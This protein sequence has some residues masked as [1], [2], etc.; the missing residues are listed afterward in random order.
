MTEVSNIKRILTS[1]R[2][3]HVG[4]DVWEQFVIPRFINEI[5]FYSKQSM[6][7]EGSR[8]SGKTMLLRYLSFQTQFSKLREYIP[9]ESMNRIGLYWKAD[10][11]FLRTMEKRGVDEDEWIGIFEN[12]LTLKLSLEAVNSIEK[13]A[14]SNCQALTF[15]DIEN[16]RILGIEDYGFTTNKLIDLHDEIS[17]KIRKFEMFIQNRK[18]IESEQKIPPTFFSYLIEGIKDST[19][20]LSNIGYSVFIDEYENLLPYQ[21]RLIN[22][23]IKSSSH[24]MT[25][26][27]AIKKNGMPIQD[28]LGPEKIQN[29]HDFSVIDLDEKIKKNDYQI[30]LAEV[31]LK[32]LCDVSDEFSKS[33]GFD[34]NILNNIDKLDLRRSEDYV[35]NCKKLVS[36][37][38]VGR[39][40]NELADEVFFSEKYHSK[41]R[42]EIE[43]AL[44]IRK[45]EES[46]TADNFININ[47]KKASIV[48]SSLLYRKTLS[49]DEVFSEFKNHTEGNESKFDNQTDWNKNNF[50]GC[51]LRI[52]SAYKQNN[53]FYS[54][55]DVYCHL[56]NGNVRHFLEL[57]RSAFSLVDVEKLRINL[58]IDHQSQHLAAR[59]AS[60]DLFKEIKSFSPM[61]HQL[62]ELAEGLGM[63]FNTI[64]NKPEQSEPEIKHFGFK[65]TATRLTEEDVRVL[66][67]AEKWGVLQLD[68]V[69]KEKTTLSVGMYEYILNPI[70]SPKFYISYRKGRKYELTASEFQKLYTAGSAAVSDIIKSSDKPDIKSIQQGLF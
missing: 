17:S 26:N 60:E 66:L 6:R 10:T 45:R 44:K 31:L 35:K 36:N 49:I 41:L 57:C 53:S 20:K 61:G 8:G 55:F 70:Y 27:I 1:I 38:L 42:S 28:T 33:I 54:G 62:T 16:L 51:Y 13:I 9:N 4:M 7:I 48:V 39:S 52:V 46:Y 68:G 11:Q 63:L 47:Y 58:V 3:E 5:D 12:Y 59:T 37:I 56:S 30:F 40:E 21:Q 64:Q 65:N 22:T 2:S 43:K 29:I 69:T 32:R 15:D 14:R 25:F 67:E 50:I 23:K 34:S 19:D 18:G 24:F